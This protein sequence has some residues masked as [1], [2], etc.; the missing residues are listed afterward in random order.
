MML[1]V[2]GLPCGILPAAGDRRR[3]DRDPSFPFLGQ[4]VGRGVALVDVPH[5]VDRAGV[6]EDPLG[7]RR[8]AG[9]DVGDDADV[10]N[11][12]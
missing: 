2:I 10:A 1:I 12:R 11:R 4:V 6:V 3:H 8:L 7:R 5:A 9:V